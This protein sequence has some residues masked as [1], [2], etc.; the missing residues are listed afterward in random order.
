MIFL[1]SNVRTMEKPELQRKCFKSYNK[2]HP[3]FSYQDDS[4]YDPLDISHLYT[5]LYGFS[6][7]SLYTLVSLNPLGF[8]I[9]N[10]GFFYT[11]VSPNR[12]SDILVYI[13]PKYIK[14]SHISQIEFLWSPFITINT[15]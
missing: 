13:Y 7:V 9:P 3:W 10:P 2:K 15:V 1:T 5:T 14:C 11:K 6:L 8:L 4:A 12:H